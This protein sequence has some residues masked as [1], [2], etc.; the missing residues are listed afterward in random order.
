MVNP[1]VGKSKMKYSRKIPKDV[2]REL[3]SIF[4]LC[5]PICG[6]RFRLHIHHIVYI[7]LG[8]DNSINNLIPLCP[9]CHDSVH[10]M[11]IDKKILI[12]IKKNWLEKGVSGE[13]ELQLIADL[14]LKV[15]EFNRDTF[16]NI[17]YVDQYIDIQENTASPKPALSTVE[18]WIF[19]NDEGGILVILGQSGCGKTTFA[20]RLFVELASNYL[21][22]PEINKFPVLVELG[23]CRKLSSLKDIINTAYFNSIIDFKKLTI[24]G[25]SRHSILVLDAFD[26]L[27]D[28]T[29]ASSSYRDARFISDVQSYGIRCII[30]SRSN[31]F[32]KELDPAYIFGQP[33]TLED[34][35]TKHSV[36]RKAIVYYLH[37][38]T[39]KQIRYFVNKM[40]PNQYH[41]I[42][43]YINDVY[44]LANLSESPLLLRMIILLLEDPSYFAREVDRISLYN[45]FIDRWYKNEIYVKK[46]RLSIEWMN[47]ILA[48]ISIKMY[49]ENRIKLTQ[50][51]IDEIISNSQYKEYE[52]VSI[53]ELQSMAELSGFL[54]I[55]HNKEWAFSHPSFQEFLIAKQF[56]IEVFSDS[57]KATLRKREHTPAVTNFIAEM[58][59]NS[60]MIIRLHEILL[61]SEL[62]IERRN[63]AM[64]LSECRKIFLKWKDREGKS[65]FNIRE[66]MEAKLNQWSEIALYGWYGGK[67]ELLKL[68]NVLKETSNSSIARIA[69]LSIG[70]IGKLEDYYLLIEAYERFIHD[71]M[72]CG[73]CVFAMAFIPNENAKVFIR[74]CL[75]NSNHQIVRRASAWAIEKSRDKDAEH[76]LCLSLGSDSDEEVRSYCAL[77]L[78]KIGSEKS[79][80]SLCTC[81]ISDNSPIV[82]IESYKSIKTILG[83]KSN[84]LIKRLLNKEKDKDVIQ[85]IISLIM[86]IENEE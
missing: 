58:S 7:S 27:A 30:L 72:V 29:L 4:K 80:K 62:S 24:A 65:Y 16:I 22:D 84:K 82:R 6:H 37:T 83:V 40:K 85:A 50:N 25:L 17:N 71:Q 48:E 42:L 46:R 53:G 81:C 78:G 63:V 64:V 28:H 10:S 34:I 31:Y 35:L 26:E 11:K 61:D 19:S 66:I 12:K 45:S 79:I 59:Q 8:G 56:S 55:S 1:N 38:F 75:R 73:A 86:V 51:E 70:F 77:A 74:E 23:K 9:N 54:N 21:S 39:M 3:L 15:E 33:L 5:C 76:Q 41:E 43:D 52:I 44:D 69:T 67:K 32:K 47:N 14:K 36:G 60:K 68:R 2:I 49:T 18:K 13:A 20:R 57:D